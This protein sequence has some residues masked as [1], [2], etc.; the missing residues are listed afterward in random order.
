MATLTLRAKTTLAGA[1]V[2]AVLSLLA[3][4]TT[5][6]LAR[7]YMLQQRA[8]ISVTQVIAASR[9]ASASLSTG[10]DGLAALSA[11][12]QLLTGSRAM[13]YRAGE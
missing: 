6:G 1:L 12:A 9:L 11:G 13:L 8:D 3:A 7:R 4:L 10:G 2:A 5:Y